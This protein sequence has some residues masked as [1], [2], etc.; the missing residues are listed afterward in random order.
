[1][2]WEWQEVLQRIYTQV[3]SRL[4]GRQLSLTQN[5]MYMVFMAGSTPCK[6]YCYS[7]TLQA[8]I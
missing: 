8:C 1:M 7:N 3:P 6:Q 4:G 5:K 2:S